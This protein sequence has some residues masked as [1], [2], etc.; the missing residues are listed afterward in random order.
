M[1][2]SVP[3]CVCERECVCR[4]STPHMLRGRRAALGGLQWLL[5]LHTQKAPAQPG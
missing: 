5:M 1:L 2:Y 4:T 3:V